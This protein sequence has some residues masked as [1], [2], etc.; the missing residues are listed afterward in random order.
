MN[1]FYNL[2]GVG[3]VLLIQLTRS[4]AVTTTTQGDVTLVHDEA[5]GELVA[6]NLFKASSYLKLETVGKV[7][8]TE[9]TVQQIQDALRKNGAEV[10]FAVDL[11]PKFVVGASVVP[12][13]AYVASPPF[14]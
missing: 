1:A 6:L 3:D 10:E 4:Q 12:I 11:T 13:T 7:E 9:E 5:T 14:C 2:K 8:L